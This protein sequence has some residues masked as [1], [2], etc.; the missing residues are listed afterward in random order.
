MVSTSI[1]FLTRDP[2]FE[3]TKPYAFRYELQDEDVPQSN[4][5]LQEQ[6]GIHVKNMRGQENRF[7][8]D[9]HGFE[10]MKISS[11]LTYEDYNDAARLPIYFRELEE[12]LTHRL[13]ASRAMVFRHGI[14]KRH[15]QFPAS[16]GRRYEYDQPTSVAHV[17]T[18]PEEL[19]EEVK[20]QLHRAPSDDRYARVEWINVWKPLRGP[21]NDWPLTLCDSSTV[22]PGEDLEAADI[23]YPDL[24]TENFQVYWNYRHQWYYLSDHEPDELLVFR[25]ASS[26]AEKLPGTSPF[27]QRGSDCSD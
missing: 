24:A 15:A 3:K 27:H 5:R 14:R 18:T 6:A 13:G 10:V 1:H 23:L 20:R 21:L 7:S 19:L 16:I 25:Q 26:P 8:L 17:D 2:E 9:H 11:E 4:L 12:L 22:I